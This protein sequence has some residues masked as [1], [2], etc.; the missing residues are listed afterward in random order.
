MIRP[1][2]LAV[3]EHGRRDLLRLRRQ[4]VRLPRIGG[5]GFVDL[6]QVADAEEQHVGDAG[7]GGD[8]DGIEADGRIGLERSPETAAAR[9]DAWRGRIRASDPWRA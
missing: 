8:A 3:D 9:W 4:V 6:G 7:I 2:Q 5:F 1:G